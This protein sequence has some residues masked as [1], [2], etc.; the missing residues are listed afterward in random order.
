MAKGICLNTG[1]THFKKGMTPW[2]KG[3][4]YI[5]LKT[6]KRTIKECVNCKKSFEIETWRLKDPRRGKFCTQNC[7]KEFNN[8]KN[9]WAF[10]KSRLDI[11]GN[12]NHF[13]K[14]GKPKCIDCQKTLSIYHGKRCQKCNLKYQIGENHHLYNKKIPS[15]TGENHHNWKG[16]VTSKERL[17]RLKFRRQI[18]KQVFKRDDYTCQICGKR[19]VDLQVDHIQSWADYVEL[20]F[21]INNCRTLCMEC[22]Y[23]ITFGKPMPPTVRAWGHNLMGGAK[24]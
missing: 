9:H 16:G 15:I 18:Q 22:H 21:D 3:K 7:F 10:G 2:N 17:E 8:G 13:W 4:S 20:R 6:R 19:G 24:L 11:S 1:R 23:Y 5:I 12:N 14:G